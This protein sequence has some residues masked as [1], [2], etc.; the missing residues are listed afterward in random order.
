[1]GARLEQ[2]R[3][4]STETEGAPKFSLLCTQKV[5]CPAGSS[6]SRV[7]WERPGCAQ[8]GGMRGSSLVWTPNPSVTLQ[9]CKQRLWAGLPRHEVA[10]G[11]GNA[12]Q[13]GG[14][15]T[16]PCTQQYSGWQE[17]RGR[18]CLLRLVV[19]EREG[20]GAWPGLDASA[21]GAAPPAEGPG[22]PQKENS[23]HRGRKEGRA[24]FSDQGS[25][26][27]SRCP[28]SWAQCGKCN[29][30]LPGQ[31]DPFR[32][33]CKCLPCK[34]LLPWQAGPPVP[35]TLHASPEGRPQDS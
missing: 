17:S 7:G 22:R 2:L 15:R 23:L 9:R 26:D 16:H 5:P 28:E 32:P 8:G 6:T 3:R 33:L 25:V 10:V 30:I 19:M 20:K 12:P 4:P 31:A 35:T 13:G 34:E 29:R 11:G 21:G 1:M 14:A 18:G 24:P 27:W